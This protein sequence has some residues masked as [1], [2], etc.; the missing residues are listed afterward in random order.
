LIIFLFTA[1]FARGAEIAEI[2]F[3]SFLSSQQK[4]KR[5]NLCALCASNDPEPAEG[6]WAVKNKMAI[7]QF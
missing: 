7:I 2:L 6:E 5:K 3:I 1:R 4:G